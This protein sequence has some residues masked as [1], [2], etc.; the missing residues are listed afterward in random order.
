[1][2]VLLLRLA[3]PLQAWGSTSRFARR[4]TENAPT[5][6]GVLGLLAAAQGRPRDADLSDLGALWFGV[7]VDQPGTRLRDFHTAHH[8]ESDKAMP[9]SERFYLADAVFV[10]GVEGE[11]ALVDALDEAVRRPA[12]LPY[13]GRRSCP[14]AQPVDLGVRAGVDLVQ[15]LEREAWHASA[16]HQ[17]R[18]QAT[19]RGGAVPLDLLLECA[20]GEEPEFTLRDAPIS[21]DPRHRRYGLRG[22]TSR[23]VEAP[24]PS[25]SPAGPRPPA[26]DPVELLRRI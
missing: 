20:P 12:F 16:W 5:K 14:P 18:A 3:G 8:A 1:M 7:R 4:S 22:L 11:P 23:T 10:A 19:A 2:S 17:R 6:S 15:A 9:L 13:L 26:H 25:P 24:M 21:F